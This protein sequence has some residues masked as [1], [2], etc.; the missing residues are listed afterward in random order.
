VRRGAPGVDGAYDA[1]AVVRWYVDRVRRQAADNPASLRA[2]YLA[3]RT[4]REQI[5]KLRE[6]GVL[7]SKAE[8]EKA[9]FASGRILRD[10]LMGMPDRMAPRLAAESDIARIHADLEGEIRFALNALADRL[11]AELV[12]PDGQTG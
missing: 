10:A 9:A 1:R 5:K 3:V 4:E 6:L 11:P 2:A 12:A 7:V 8:V